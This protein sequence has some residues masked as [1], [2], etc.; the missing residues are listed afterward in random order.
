MMSN[1]SKKSKNI[2]SSANVR[3][4]DRTS[5]PFLTV[6]KVIMLLL[7]AVYPL[8]MV[9][10]SGAGL[11]YN[12]GSYGEEL[13]RIGF[14]LIASSA[15]MVAGA[16][17][18]IFRR[19]LCSLLSAV[20]TVAG[21]TLCMVMLFKLTSHADTAGWSDKYDMTPIS[22]MYKARVVPTILPVAMC[23]VLAAVQ[24]FSYDEQEERREKKKIKLERENAD[25]PR[26]IGDD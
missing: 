8:T 4:I 5:N 20:L 7:T 23:L 17:L 10:L 9:S 15:L 16:V 13:T 18:C 21:C 22:S 12:S 25:A 19:S 6:M 26:I 14:M 24:F 2:R 11:I 1:S 3:R